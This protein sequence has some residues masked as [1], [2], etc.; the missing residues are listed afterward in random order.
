LNSSYSENLL[1]DLLKVRPDACTDSVRA[2]HPAFQ[3]MTQDHLNLR[4]DAARPRRHAF[5]GK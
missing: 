3:A 1:R 4:I 5:G 2:L